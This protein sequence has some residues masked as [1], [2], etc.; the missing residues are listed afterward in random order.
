MVSPNLERALITASSRQLSYHPNATT[1]AAIKDKTLVMLV[2]PV[3]VGKSFITSH[4]VD[5]APDFK[6]VSVIT[7]RDPRPDDD[8]TLFRA[9]P[10]DDSH[11]QQILTSIENGEMVNYTIHPTSHRIYGTFASDYPG[12]FNVLPTLSG[13]V[14][15][16][17]SMPF[18]RTFI[19]GISTDPDTWK[20][21]LLIRYPTE[22]EEKT[23]RLKE[24]IVSLTWL[25]DPAQ[26]KNVHWV[27]NPANS[28]VAI[29]S[30]IDI[31]KYN[32][33]ESKDAKEDARR[34]LKVAEELVR[35]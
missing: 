3:A 34:M 32:K 4:L 22:S 20:E 31:V 29:Q 12:T 16:L 19:V 28:Q 17:Q 1:A 23:K 14:A 30:V 7:T 8:P 10:H 11:V 27:S 35:S 25:L 9:V 21:R 15:Q 6:P 18:K 13:A 33:Q 5:A 26:D 2:S 24:A